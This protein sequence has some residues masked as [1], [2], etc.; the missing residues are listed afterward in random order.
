MADALNGTTTRQELVDVIR[1]VRNRWRMRLLLQG[2]VIVL[3]GAL[4]AIALASYGLQEYKFS[5]QAVTGFRI[6]VFAVFALLMGVWLIRPMGRKV[7]D[8]QVALYVEEHEP[9]LQ[10]AILS[11][12]DLGATSPGGASTDVPAAIVDKMVAQ[13]IEKCKTIEGGRTVGRAGMRR[14]AMALGLIASVGALLLVIG[15]EFLRQGASAL[16]V[17]SRSAEAASPYAINVLPGDVEIPK[18]SDQTIAA[19][20]AGFRSNDVGVWVKAEGQEKFVRVPLV[21]TGEAD[22][23]EGMLFDLKASVSY[24]VEA[25]GVKSPTYAMTVVELPA[26]SALEMEYVYPAYTGLAPQTVEVGGDVAAL[27][28]TEVRFKITSTMQT[29]GGRLKLEPGSEAALA[30]EADGTTLTGKFTIKEDGYYHV[31]LDGPRGKKVM[32]SPKYTVDVIE[33]RAPSVSIEKPKRDTSANPVEEVFVQAKAQD[34]FGV[35]QLDHFLDRKS[36]V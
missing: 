27:A 36:V 11:A 1:Q 10:A 8:M 3:V 21:A 4:A 7:T 9:S 2:A 18:G 24:Y 13:A 23:H 33:D 26:V 34:D 28:G 22:K 29:P 32:A 14:S 16:L 17:L 30:V 6:G 12:V 31:E 19:R 15:P 25:D 5:P 20:L 35:R